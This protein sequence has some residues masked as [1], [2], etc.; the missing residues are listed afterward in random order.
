MCID[1]EDLGYDRKK[2]IYVDPERLKVWLYF[3][4]SEKDKVND[5]MWSGKFYEYEWDA[6]EVVNYR[7]GTNFFRIRIS[8][9]SMSKEERD[10][11][12]QFVKEA[13]D[14]GEIKDIRFEV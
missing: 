7:K 12:G 8:L 10:K 13:F 14:R 1:S 4:L 3:D 2:G 11:F 9:W 6:L 5:I